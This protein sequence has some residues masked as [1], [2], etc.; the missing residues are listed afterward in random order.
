M[1]SHEPSLGLR[2]YMYIVRNKISI[3]MGGM[4]KQ[5]P[6]LISYI[7]YVHTWT[8]VFHFKVGLAEIKEMP[9]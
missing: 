4:F 7:W 8:V 6:P 2:V 9:I 5:T 3:L 1:N